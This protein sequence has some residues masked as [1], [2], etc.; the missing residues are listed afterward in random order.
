MNESRG[1]PARW[2]RPLVRYAHGSTRSV[3]KTAFGRA[4]RSA[5]ESRRMSQAVCAERAGYDHSLVSRLESGGRSPSRAVV[6]AVAK[7]LWLDGAETDALLLAAGFAPVG[8][9]GN[10]PAWAGLPAVRSLGSAL[11]ALS[12][13]EAAR[14][15]DAVSLLIAGATTARPE[16]ATEEA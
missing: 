7:A 11:V 13:P 14:L 4:L 9:V 10:V 12:A 3:P 16:P 15:A 2:D 8:P 5:R 6:V 1:E